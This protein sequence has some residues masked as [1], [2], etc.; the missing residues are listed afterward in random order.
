MVSFKRKSAPDRRSPE[1]LYLSI[2]VDVGV[3]YKR[4]LGRDAAHAFFNAQDIP[5]PVFMRVM[6]DQSP[7]RQTLWEESA[8]SGA[9][10]SEMKP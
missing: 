4:T 10:E 3:T 9:T 2:L 8:M 6:A 1:N 7:R 5:H